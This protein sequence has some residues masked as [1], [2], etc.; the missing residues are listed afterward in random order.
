MKRLLLVLI[1]FLPFTAWSQRWKSIRYEV[2]YGLGLTN[3]LGDLGGANQIGTHYFKDLDWNETGIVANVGLRYKLSEYTAIR[4]NLF[5]GNVSG[6]DKNTTEQFR[7]N[8]N[9]SFY[10]NIIELSGVFEASFTKEKLG[11]RYKLRGIKGQTHLEIYPYAFV[12]L[13]LFYFNPQ[14]Q[15]NGTWYPLQPLGTEGQGV[16]PSREK[17]SRIQ[18]AIPL[19]I[20]FKKSINSR[21]GISFE[22]GIR[23][24]FTDYI[25]DVSTTYV[26][27]NILIN[28]PGGSLAA[29][30]ANRSEHQDPKDPMYGST[31]AGQQRGD[32]RYTDS[33]MFAVFSATYKLKNGRGHLPKF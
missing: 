25:D 13:G 16:I 5:I 22:Y 12:G 14:A 27:K 3:F 7:S 15:M 33:Y 26:D 8:R 19:G 29:T 32:S 28:G 31:V 24:T 23:K 2:N 4:S 9:L 17:Y 21:W 6:N 10:S 30:L 11:H 18:V 20:G 1:I